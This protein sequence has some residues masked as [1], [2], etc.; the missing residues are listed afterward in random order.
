MFLE[1]KSSPLINLSEKS[2]GRRRR[3]ERKIL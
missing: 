3:E 1:Q 2:Q